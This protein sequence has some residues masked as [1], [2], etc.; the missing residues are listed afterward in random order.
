MARKRA[1]DSVGGPSRIFEARVPFCGITAL[2]R[3]RTAEED[4]ALLGP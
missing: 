2:G 3:L 4:L 1:I